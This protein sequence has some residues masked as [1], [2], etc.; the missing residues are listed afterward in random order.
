MFCLIFCIYRFSVHISRVWSRCKYALVH[1]HI[2]LHACAVHT[3]IY[4][5]CCWYY[6]K[7]S[8]L[9]VATTSMVRLLHNTIIFLKLTLNSHCKR[10]IW[11]QNA[12]SSFIKELFRYRK[13][14]YY[15]GVH[16]Q[17]TEGQHNKSFLHRKSS[18]IKKEK[19]GNNYFSLSPLPLIWLFSLF[20]SRRLHFTTVPHVRFRG[21]LEST[22]GNTQIRGVID[23][24]GYLQGFGDPKLSV[25]GT[26]VL[27]Y[28]RIYVLLIAIPW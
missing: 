27:Y 10:I 20:T 28:A 11:I 9:R 18:R 1:I 17:D 26:D 13:S 23:N 12:S 6:S 16:A 22:R 19:L 24:S 5:S 4:P 8:A 15:T 14:H 25:P 2:W 3:Y 7:Y 21:N